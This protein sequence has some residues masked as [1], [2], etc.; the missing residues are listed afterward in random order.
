MYSDIENGKPG[1]YL[2]TRSTVQKMQES[3]LEYS[4]G[5]QDGI[6]CT[7]IKTYECVKAG[8]QI[9]YQ[10]KIYDI[11]G[12]RS[13]VEGSFL[14]FEYRLVEPQM[15][16]QKVISNMKANGVTLCG[17]VAD[18]SV[19]AVK[20]NFDIDQDYETEAQN[21]YPWRTITSNCLYCMPEKDAKVLINLN[22]DLGGE[23]RGISCMRKGS[24]GLNP[25]TKTFYTSSGKNIQLSPQTIFAGLQS[26]Q[27]SPSSLYIKDLEKVAFTTDNFISIEEQKEGIVVRGDATTM[28]AF[29]QLMLAMLE[30][31]G[32]TGT[33]I[34]LNSTIE[35]YGNNVALTGMKRKEFSAINDEPAEIKIDNQKLKKLGMKVLLALAAVAVA[36]VV[37]VAVAAVVA[38]TGGTALAAIG[39]IIGTVAF[40]CM[41]GGL[42][43]AS[44][45]VYEQIKE[46]KEKGIKHTRDDYVYQGVDK[47]CTGVILT[48][49]AAAVP[50]GGI[51]GLFARMVGTAGASAYYQDVDS[52]LNAVFGS[53]F[54]DA[55]S[56]F[57]VSLGLD[58][59]CSGFGELLGKIF[60]PV[61]NK[62]GEAVKG[63]IPLLK[64]TGRDGARSYLRT[65]V[66]NPNLTKENW[67][68]IL[69]KA[70]KYN[71]IFNNIVKGIQDTA[72]GISANEGFS[73]APQLGTGE[74][75]E[76]EFKQYI[77]FPYETLESCK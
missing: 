31:E 67:K 46:D 4:E 58:V 24:S 18:V 14:V 53:D 61:F 34:S 10:G 56:N 29:E 47:F 7:L 41:M 33:N 54:Y 76:F 12:K 69:D 5:M 65:I 66:K 17:N 71:G 52:K 9:E 35:L 16:S 74:I 48:A 68:P 40:T 57:W 51:L 1:I 30:D 73:H 32:T 27:N 72:T 64:V 59:A 28:S 60:G 42:T 22:D 23:A 8:A 44:V 77:D 70:C 50:G 49:P 37:A 39:P 13:K 3:I 63:R 15:N 62:V 25:D 20:V 6:P 45:T 36:C 55:D 11:I 38:A 26:P 75:E 43:Y 2:G 21:N 19:D